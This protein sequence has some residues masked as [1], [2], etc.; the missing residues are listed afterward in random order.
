MCDVCYDIILDKSKIY[1]LINVFTQVDFDL[2]DYSK[3]CL[4]S[5]DWRTIALHYFSLFRQLQYTMPDYEYNDIER[6]MLWDNR[7]LIG[8]HSK[9]T[10]PLLASIKW[11]TLSKSDHDEMISLLYTAKRRYSCWSMMLE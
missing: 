11:D 3:I 1:R 10:I 8:G 6:K 7:H 4:V 9:Y 2:R 5:K